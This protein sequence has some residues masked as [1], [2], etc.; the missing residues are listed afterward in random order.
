MSVCQNIGILVHIHVNYFFL[1]KLLANS[2]NQLP[3]KNVMNKNVFLFSH[4]CWVDCFFITVNNMIALSTKLFS[5][6]KLTKDPSFF[7]P[8]SI[9]STI[10]P[11]ILLLIQLYILTLLQLLLQCR[12]IISHYSELYLIKLDHFWQFPPWHDGGIESAAQWNYI[13]VKYIERWLARKDVRIHNYSL[14][15]AS[16]NRNVKCWFIIN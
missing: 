6:G 9:D 11:Y 3:H 13:N 4:K 16:C 7:Q 10:Y 1:P 2:I 5:T 8:L 15:N 12:W 14:S